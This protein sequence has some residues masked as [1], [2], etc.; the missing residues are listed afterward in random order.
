MIRALPSRRSSRSP[1]S[2][3]GGGLP[4]RAR[5]RAPR[6]L[7]GD[8]DRLVRRGGRC[9]AGASEILPVHELHRQEVL[10]SVS[11]M[12]YTRHTLGARPGGPCAP[13]GEPSSG[14]G[15]S[16]AR[17]RNLR[18]TG[19]PSSG[20]RPGRPRP[21]R[22]AEQADQAVTLAEDR[23]RHEALAGPRA[24]SPDRPGAPRDG[25]GGRRGGLPQ[26]A[27]AGRCPSGCR[28]RPGWSRT[29]DRN[30]APPPPASSRP[31]RRAPSDCRG[32][33]T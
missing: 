1:A 23:A 19:W 4:S 9:A 24:R 3:R 25:P 29:P 11:P 20:R 13:P 31:G 33:T 6:R 18:A 21:S 2:G 14:R 28:P 30:G 7:A 16:S 15:H 12:S 32:S 22:P 17:G 26:R 8:L 5:R 10:A 27:A